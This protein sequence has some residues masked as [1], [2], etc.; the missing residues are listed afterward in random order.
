MGATHSNHLECV[1]AAVQKVIELGYA[2]PAKI[3]LHGHSFSGQGGNYIVTHTDLFACAIIGAGASNMVS[4]FNQL[5]KSS[6]TNQHRYNYL[7]QGRFGTNPFDDLELYIDQS[8][9]Y[10]ARDMN[11]PLILFHG[12]SDGSVEWLQAIEFYNALRFNNK[13][14][15]LCSYP[16]EGHHLSK[17]ENKVD[18]QTRM[19]QF[20]DHYL[21]GTKAPEWMIKGI[22]FLEKASN[23]N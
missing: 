9:T 17:Y 20:Y 15:I 23:N 6:G 2:D 1:E 8:A 7:G 4:D 5:W 19:E 14:V 3:G 12:T 11:T 18:F 22:P 21:K 13:N 16:G 10:H